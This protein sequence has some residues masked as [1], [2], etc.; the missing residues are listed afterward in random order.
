M[1]ATTTTTANNKR[2]GWVILLA[3]VC[4]IPWWLSYAP[5]KT[6]T[7]ATTSS[8]S[9]APP[10]YTLACGEGIDQSI[11]IPQGIPK[12]QLVP[13]V[14]PCFTG[15]I[16]LP[17]HINTWRLFPSG[18]VQ[19]QCPEGTC[20]PEDAPGEMHNLPNA[21]I[22]PHMWLRVKSL[23]KEKVVFINISFDY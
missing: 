6:T 18:R 2:M 23:E 3:L 10:I 17:Q 22:P 21:K 7:Q 19:Y 11:V 13:P 4:A 9:S 15:Q 14:A 16:T 1:S 20:P 12:I 8:T 5:H